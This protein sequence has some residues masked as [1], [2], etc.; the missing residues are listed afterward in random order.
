ML[1]DFIMKMSAMRSAKEERDEEIGSDAC[2]RPEVS[3]QPPRGE[4]P[5]SKIREPA[6]RSGRLD[7][8]IRAP[9]DA[10]D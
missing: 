2:M 6:R 5:G 1:E 10:Q 3:S 8:S 7:V 4:F 9:E